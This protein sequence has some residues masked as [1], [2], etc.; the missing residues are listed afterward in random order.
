MQDP[1]LSNGRRTN[2][3]RANLESPQVIPVGTNKDDTC[4]LSA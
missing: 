1:D 3:R 4:S 2:G